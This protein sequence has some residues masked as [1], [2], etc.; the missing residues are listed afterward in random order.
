MGFPVETPH[1]ASAWI[2]PIGSSVLGARPEGPSKAPRARFGKAS[3]ADDD[4]GSLNKVQKLGKIIP[5]PFSF[6]GEQPIL[7]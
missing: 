5:Q 3:P 1:P 4:T 6:I 2:P 7:L